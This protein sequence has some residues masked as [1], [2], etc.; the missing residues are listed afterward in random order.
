MIWHLFFGSL[1]GGIFLSVLFINCYKSGEISLDSKLEK[2]IFALALTP[3]VNVIILILVQTGIYLEK[4]FHFFKKK[5]GKIKTK[6][7]TIKAVNILIKLKRKITNR[8]LCA[9]SKD[10]KL[11]N[12]TVIVTHL[13]NFNNPRIKPLNRERK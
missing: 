10:G 4:L 12:G 1:I 9:T 5:F 3:V 2:F 6:S 8:H 7:R 11:T 13:S